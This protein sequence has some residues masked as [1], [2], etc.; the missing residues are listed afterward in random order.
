MFQEKLFILIWLLTYIH[1]THYV[2]RNFSVHC[3][4]LFGYQLMIQ[5]QILKQPF[6]KLEGGIEAI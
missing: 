3:S 6:E 1:N 5:Y 4:C 2:P